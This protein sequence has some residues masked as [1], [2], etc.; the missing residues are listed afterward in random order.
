MSVSCADLDEE[1]WAVLERE[2]Q[3]PVTPEDVRRSKSALKL[4]KS[5]KHI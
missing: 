2:I 3:R 1:Q 4:V 5:W